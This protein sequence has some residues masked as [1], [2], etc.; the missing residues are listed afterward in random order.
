MA[1]EKVMNELIPFSMAISHYSR[2]L[3][4]ESRY[5]QMLSNSSQ[6]IAQAMRFLPAS[7]APLREII[8]FFFLTKDLFSAIS[9]PSAVKTKTSYSGAL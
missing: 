2:F 7:S 5:A 8:F 4:L 6:S 9:A 3:K 1:I